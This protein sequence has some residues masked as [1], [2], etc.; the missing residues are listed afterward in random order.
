[1]NE[2]L[3]ARPENPAQQQLIEKPVCDQRSITE[4]AQL[5]V[6]A[7]RLQNK[8]CVEKHEDPGDMEGGSEVPHHLLQLH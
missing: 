2:L 8:H 1:M 7:S 6:I 5:C 3:L 4:A